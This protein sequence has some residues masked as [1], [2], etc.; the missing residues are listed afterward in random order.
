MNNIQ[1]TTLSSILGFAMI[2]MLPIQPKINPPIHPERIV[3]ATLD[4]PAPVQSIL[5]AACKDC[6]SHETRW[7]WY[8]NIAPVSW[9]I[10]RDVNRARRAMDLSEW[11]TRPLSAAG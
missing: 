7:P 10:A 1:R 2:Q 9:W 5:T 6:H 8:A 3:E 11:S 4:V